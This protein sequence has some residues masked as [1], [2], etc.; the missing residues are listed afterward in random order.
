MKRSAALQVSFSLTKR[1]TDLGA[2]VISPLSVPAKTIEAEMARYDEISWSYEREIMG[3]VSYFLGRA[4][5]DGIVFLT[6]FGCGTFPVISELIDREVRGE[7]DKPLL[8][9]VVDEMTGEGGI[10]TRLESFC[11]MIQARKEA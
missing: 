5:V 2:R 1:L 7:R 11:D 9:L 3:T 10:Q 8:Y 4:D 6:S